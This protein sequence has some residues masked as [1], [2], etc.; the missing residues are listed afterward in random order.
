MAQ[1]TLKST[2]SKLRPVKAYVQSCMRSPKR[3]KVFCLV[4]A[5]FDMNVYSSRLSNNIDVRVAY[6]DKE[7]KYKHNR[8]TVERFVKELREEFSNIRIIGIRDVDYNEYT[9]HI[10]PEGV[11]GTDDRD[12]EMMIFHSASFDTFLQSAMP[13]Y[14]NVMVNCFKA[15][16]CLGYIRIFDEHI[17]R[18]CKINQKVKISNVYDSASHDYKDNYSSIMRTRYIDNC[19]MTITND[20]IDNYV[21]TNHLDKESNYIVCRGHDMLSLLGIILGNKFHEPEMHKLMEKYYSKSDFYSTSLFGEIE[22]YC[23]TFGIC[24]KC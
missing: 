12:L 2:T 19:Q 14:D 8:A 11:L 20:D 1:E 3:L 15:C 9:T 17:G 24:A 6:T 21:D 10:M 18:K 13:N 23:N 5:P 16:R 7:G 22:K 4:E